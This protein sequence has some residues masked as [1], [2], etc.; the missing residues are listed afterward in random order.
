MELTRAIPAAAAVPPRKA[1]GRIQ[2][3]GNAE[4]LPAMA[5]LRASDCK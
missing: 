5:R 4:R 2:N 3:T 1:V